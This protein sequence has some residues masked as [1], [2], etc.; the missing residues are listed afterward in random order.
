MKRRLSNRRRFAYIRERA[1]FRPVFGQ[2]EYRAGRGSP[3]AGEGERAVDGRRSLQKPAVFALEVF[4]AYGRT[5]VARSAAALSYFLILTLFPLL[6][7]VNYFIGLFHLDLEQMLQGLDQLLPSGALAVIG[8]YLGYAAQAQSPALLGAGLFTLVASASAGLRT[9]FQAMDELWQAGRRAPFRRLVLSV[10]LSL[11][12]LLTIYL[13]VVVI[14]TGDWFFG[15]LESRLP[16]RLAAL[17]PLG[18]LSGLWRWL[19]Y[20]LLFCFVLALVLVIY[21]AGVSRRAQSDRVT[22]ATALLTALAMVACSAVFSWFIGLSSRYA[23]VYGSL[24]SLIIL[25]VWLYLC[26]NILLLGAVAGW[27]WSRGAGGGTSDK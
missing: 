3:A 18:L 15:F 2:T 23:L 22:L 1:V 25:L 14:F 11:L 16:R 21:R 10:V 19:R 9:L 7:C 8:D 5:G 6:M 13:S 26:G 27:V 24:A 20:L 4:R 17:L 12:F